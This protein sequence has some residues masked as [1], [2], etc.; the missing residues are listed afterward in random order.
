MITFFKIG[1]SLVLA[2]AVILIVLSLTAKKTFHTEVFIPAPPEEVWQVL[3]DTA[4]YPDWNP[5]FVQVQGD[6]VEGDTVTNTVK[7][8]HGDMTIKAA[9][10]TVRP[11]RELQQTGGLFGVITFDHRWILK[12]EGQGTCV[13]QHEVDRGFYLWF[14]N[15]DWVQPAYERAS[16]ALKNRVTG[17]QTGTGCASN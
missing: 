16:D 14:W 13:T 1:G 6:Y 7:S 5:T 4:S 17:D 3:M 15:S 9:I 10:E 11:N 8:P 12:P 2:L